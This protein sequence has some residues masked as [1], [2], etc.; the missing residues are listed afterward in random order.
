MSWMSPSTPL[1]RPFRKR[2]K[3][4]RRYLRFYA[5]LP[6]IVV[7]SRLPIGFARRLGRAAG[8]LGWLV[9]RGDR[10]RAMENLRAAFG[11]QKS[12]RELRRI[13]REVFRNVVV[14]TF[15]LLVVRRW[16]PERIR[17]EFPFEEEF[18]RID[19]AHPLGTVG[20][21]AHLGNWELLGI[22][23]SVFL[24]GRLV[25]IAKRIYFPKLQ[26]LM[27]RFRKGVGLEVI[28]TDE[29]FRRILRALRDGKI[30]GILPDQDLKA[31]NGVFVDFFGRPAYTSTVPANLA[32][33]TGRD[34]TFI[35]LLRE[36]GKYRVIHHVVPISPTGRREEDLL[37]ITRSWMRILEEDVR[38]HVDQWVWFHRR[39]RT[40]PEEGPRQEWRPGRRRRSEGSKADR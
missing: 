13:C 7:L 16:S 15:E 11:A 28:Y 5:M 31:L 3:D 21:T 4:F 18:R 23:F 6:F 17:R 2:F 32:L 25:A 29:S 24:P 36:G 9:V 37:E 14:D 33:T 22:L 30:V 34:M 26:D 35:I 10:V 20:L 8:T 12:P 19:E 40:R 38:G 39:W 1:R 27:D